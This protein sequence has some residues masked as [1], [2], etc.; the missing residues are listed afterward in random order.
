[1]QNIT[2]KKQKDDNK[3][4]VYTD[5]CNIVCVAETKIDLKEFV[6]NCTTVK[7]KNFK[8]ACCMN[9]LFQQ[10]KPALN[11]MFSQRAHLI[12]LTTPHEPHNK[13]RGPMVL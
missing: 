11:R 1:M 4:H 5:L 9:K 2:T 3:I 8:T 7:I 6:R 10:L 12:M 13:T